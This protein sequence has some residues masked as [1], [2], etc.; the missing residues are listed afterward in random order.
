MFGA[1]RRVDGISAIVA[2]GRTQAVIFVEIGVGRY[3]GATVVGLHDVACGTSHGAQ[4]GTIS[5][6]GRPVT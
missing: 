4:A 6:F 1:Q 2:A 3:W 5:I